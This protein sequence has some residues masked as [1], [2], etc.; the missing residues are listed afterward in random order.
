MNKQYKHLF[1]PRTEL[2]PERVPGEM[3]R[4][5]VEEGA[6]P[7]YGNYYR[8]SPQQQTALKE[9]VSEYV[10]AGKMDLCVGSSWVPQ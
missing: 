9:L 4:I 3:F 1:E 8:L 7:Q 6:T 5:Q 10:E 2:P